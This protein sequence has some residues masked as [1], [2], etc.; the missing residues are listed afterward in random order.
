MYKC[1]VSKIVS[2]KFKNNTKGLFKKVRVI[3]QVDNQDALFINI[4]LKIDS[5]NSTDPRFQLSQIRTKKVL[6]SNN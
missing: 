5:R 1:I 4:K 2:L 6:F 3:L